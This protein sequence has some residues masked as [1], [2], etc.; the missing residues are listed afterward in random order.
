MTTATFDSAEA[1]IKFSSGIELNWD[2]FTIPIPEHVVVYSTDQKKFKVGD[3]HHLYQ[4]LVDGPSIAGIIAH[5][6]SNEIDIFSRLRLVDN[7]KIIIPNGGIFVAGNV[8]LADL[9]SRLNIVISSSTLRDAN[10]VVLSQRL[11]NVD[12]SV[13]T[14]D[15]AKLTIVN[16]HKL[17]PG[18]LPEAFTP[19]KVSPLSIMSVKAYSDKACTTP[20]TRFAYDSTYYIKVEATHDTVDISLLSY[21]LVDDNVYTTVTNIG[22]GIFRIDVKESPADG[23]LNFTATITYSTDT[24]TDHLSVALLGYVDPATNVSGI[25]VYSDITCKLPVANLNTDTTYYAKISINSIIDVSNITFGL[26]ESSGLIHISNLG[27]GKFKLD[28]AEPIDNTVST[29]TG[30]A[31]YGTILSTLTTLVSL[32]AYIPALHITNIGVFT[33]SDCTI[34]T[35][36][37]NPDSTYYAKITGTYGNLTIDKVAFTLTNT[38]TYVNITP[39]NNNIFKIDITEPPLTDTI[40]LNGSVSYRTALVSGAIAVTLK[41]LIPPIIISGV[42]VYSDLACTVSVALLN[43]NTTYY[44]K[45][46][47]S[48]GSTDVS[49]IIFSLTSNNTHAVVAANLGLGVFR[50]DVGSSTIAADITFNGTAQHSD[51][52]S[53]GINYLNNTTVNNL[54]LNTDVT[55]V[56][57]GGPRVTLNP[58]TNYTT[59]TA[60]SNLPLNTSISMVGKG[61]PRT[62]ASSGTNWVWPANYNGDF[63]FDHWRDPNA[64]VF[65]DITPQYFPQLNSLNNVSV[66]PILCFN[67]DSSSTKV[68][69][70]SSDLG[71]NVINP[72]PFSITYSWEENSTGYT[73]SFVC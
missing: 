18:I 32:R 45:I 62:V 40:I 5:Q 8:S 3:G 56:G 73:D 54:P 37:F 67:L 29:L 20:V 41:P 55:L 13:N 47:A 34:T 22:D 49:Q 14:S 17:A 61:G 63:A 26:T 46:I 43:P 51:S 10:M 71:S 1:I 16:N 68:A 28:V 36:Q 6:N 59:S 12:N 21:M 64:E 23:L 30:T 69:K 31:A 9:N 35:T 27:S 65:A 4:E 53:S 58:S 60:L 33:D 66:I 44:A 50:I 72:T 57:K 7:N 2:I 11:A 42:G 24:V 38:N 39:I 48:Y 70:I 25:I 15:N 19:N 52:T